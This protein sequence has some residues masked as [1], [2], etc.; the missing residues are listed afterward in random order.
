MSIMLSWSL[1]GWIVAVLVVIGLV[2]VIR[3]LWQ[4]ILR[5]LVHIVLTIVGI[6]AILAFL[7]YVIRLF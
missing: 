6:I 7:H 5:F 1:S 2:V 4:H 3:F